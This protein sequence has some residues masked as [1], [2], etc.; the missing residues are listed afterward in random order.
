MHLILSEMVILHA[1]TASVASAG[2][3]E[4][5]SYINT[6]N[7]NSLSGLMATSVTPAV[8]IQYILVSD[9]RGLAVVK[10]SLR[11]LEIQPTTSF[12]YNDKR[13]SE[14]YAELDKNSQI[15]KNRD[16]FVLNYLS[17]YYN[18]NTMKKYIEF[19]SMSIDEF[20]GRNEDLIETYDII[21]IGGKIGNYYYTGSDIN[22]YA[23]VDGIYNPVSTVANADGQTTAATQNAVEK[24]LP[25]Y[26]D[27]AM[28]GMIYYNIGDIVTAN[29]WLLGYLDTDPSTA[30]SPADLANKASNRDKNITDLNG[31]TSTTRYPGRDITKT[32]LE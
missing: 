3:S 2:F 18:N 1:Y 24:D 17:A 11:I 14:E 27:K 10:N 31:K 5:L 29:N 13:G 15:K 21:Y 6:T 16:D 30:I 20:N 22:T 8:A 19:D 26:K 4:V 28:T 23:E 25:V 7:K 12:L 9:G 32:K